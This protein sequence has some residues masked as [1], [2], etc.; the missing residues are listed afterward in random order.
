MPAKKKTP[1]P[2]SPEKRNLPE[3]SAAQDGAN[4]QTATRM[5]GTAPRR[6]QMESFGEG[7]RLFHARQLGEAKELF[8]AASS[9]PDRAVSHRAALHARMC[10]S[11]LG[12]P[13]VVLATPEDRYNYAITLINS[14]DFAG[15]QEH[16]RAALAAEPSAD[17]V[18]YALAACQGLTGDLQGA[19][20]NLK[21]A[22]DLQPRNRLAARQDPDFAPFAGQSA[23]ARLLYPDKKN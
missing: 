17:H 15:A 20:E 4:G 23:F 6:T 13:G 3:V 18:L 7:M 9:G 10:E 5:T 2:K 22:I 8:L 11:R 14:R 12:S 21:R 16:L 19:Y 1:I